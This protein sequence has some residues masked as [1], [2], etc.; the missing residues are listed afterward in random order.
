[1]TGQIAFQHTGDVVAKTV[2]MTRVRHGSLVLE[3]GGRQ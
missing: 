2:A 3:S 1:V